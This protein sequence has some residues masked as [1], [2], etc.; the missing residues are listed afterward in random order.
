MKTELTKYA[1]T[2]LLVPQGQ[3]VELTIAPMGEHAAFTQP[4]YTV[5]LLPMTAS[6]EPR[7]ESGYDA[8][9]VAPSADG[10]L[11]VTY[12]F[13]GEQEHLVRI[14]SEDQVIAT[15]SV[16]SLEADLYGRVPLRGDFHSHSFRSDGRESPAIVAANYRK[17]GYD[18]LAITDH[19]QW[20]PSQE[21][22]DAY[23]GAPV[24]L[25]L[26]HGEEVHTPGNHIHIINFGGDFSVNSL[27]W[28]NEQTYDREVAAIRQTL[29]E[30]P[31]GVDADEY[32]MCLWSIGKIHQGGGMAIYCHPHWIANVYHVRDAMTRHVLRNMP[33]DAFELL[34]GQTVAENNMQTAIWND[35]R[36]QGAKVA[37][38]GASDSHGTVNANWFGWTS[39]VVLACSH[40][41]EDIIAAVREGN[42]AAVETYAG[43]QMRA[44][45]TYRLV[46]LVRFL[47][48]N[49]F[50]LH[51]ELCFEEGRAMR[52]YVCGEADG[53]K[54]LQATQGRTARLLARCYGKSAR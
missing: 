2:P 34:G 9:E 8:A 40:S 16:Y 15:L 29:G 11:R 33:F 13:P 37:I 12:A 24:D 10:T 7:D 21:A 45:G 4:R 18:F 23:R 49:Y 51:D 53:L 5:R 1:I 48:D 36:A 47:L 39:T 41:R 30:L 50:P 42:S 26:F 52:D 19:R 14:L 38:V 32:A 44:H 46:S 22:I 31:E 3:P 17:A 27:A 28:D 6:V 43:E 25:R 20:Q 35:L 54:M